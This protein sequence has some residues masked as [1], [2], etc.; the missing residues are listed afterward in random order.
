[1]APDDRPSL[2]RY[3]AATPSEVAGALSAFRAH[4]DVEM[5]PTYSAAALSSAT[6]SPSSGRQGSSAS[7]DDATPFEKLP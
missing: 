4:G 3:H 5:L 1:V 6:F 2:L 7:R